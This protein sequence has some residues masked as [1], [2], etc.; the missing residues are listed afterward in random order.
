MSYFVPYRPELLLPQK[1]LQDL[2]VWIL[3]PKEA[4]TCAPP[5]IVHVGHTLH[6]KSHSKI[7]ITPLNPAAAAVTFM[8][9]GWSISMSHRQSLMLWLM[10]Q[11]LRLRILKCLLNTEASTTVQ[12]VHLGH[13]P[14]MCSHLL[15][16]IHSSLQHSWSM[17][18]VVVNLDLM[19]IFTS[20]I[21]RPHPDQLLS[22]QHIHHHYYCDLFS[23]SICNNIRWGN[24]HVHNNL[25]WMNVIPGGTTA[26]SFNI[27][28]PGLKKTAHIHDSTNGFPRKW[29]FS[30]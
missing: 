24:S 19:G 26:P 5:Q 22:W 3:Q 13:T 27:P 10:H 2:Q 17:L 6:T 23:L 25:W 1:L 30:N 15:G 29:C 8:F 16:V 20:R 4:K 7:S 14:T 9:Q 18:T 12:H 21:N 28:W 11:M